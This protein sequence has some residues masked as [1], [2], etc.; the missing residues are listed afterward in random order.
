MDDAIK[1]AVV[2][3]H[4]DDRAVQGEAFRFLDE[5]TN[6]PVGWAYQVWDHLLKG[7][8]SKDNRLRS[9]ASQ[10]LCN[11]AKSDPE[12]RILIDFNALLDVTRDDRFVT[13]RHC[14]LAIWKIG[15]SGEIQKQRVVDGLERRFEECAAEKNCT[16]IRF[17]IIQGLRKLYD[18]VKDESIRDKALDLIAKEADLKYRKK[19]AGLWR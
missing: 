10:L 15:A 7:L 19:Y 9:I 1:S 3:I 2:N 18:H 8:T 12:G 5:L 13:A 11:L 6:K 14:L 4:S 16:L 17:D